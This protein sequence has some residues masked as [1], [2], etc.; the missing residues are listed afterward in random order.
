MLVVI[1]DALVTGV[2][3]LILLLIAF[4]QRRQLR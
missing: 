1:S 4:D 2:S 3:D